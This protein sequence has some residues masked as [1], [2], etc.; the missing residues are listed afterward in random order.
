MM[1]EFIPATDADRKAMLIQVADRLSTLHRYGVF[2]GDLKPGNVMIDVHGRLRLLDF[3]VARLLDES[4]E[5]GQARYLTPGYAA[6]ELHRGQRPRPSSDVFALGK[7]LADVL[8][9]TSSTSGMHDRELRAIA[10]LATDPVPERRYDSADAFA[11]D[12]QRA[13]TGHPVEAWGG[14]PAICFE[15]RDGSS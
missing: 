2:Y 1:H 6:P 14:G 15:A 10:E 7:M 4:S 5:G 3:G 11:G 8:S 9:W 13:L 12:L